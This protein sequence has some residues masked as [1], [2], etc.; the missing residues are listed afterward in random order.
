MTNRRATQAASAPDSSTDIVLRALSDHRRRAML[1]LVR[2]G[3]R[4]AGEI[5]SEF[6]ITQQAVSQH[7]QVL[8]QAGL[9][10]ERADGARRLYVLRPAALEPVRAVLDAL[11]PVALDR[12][13]RVV[14]QDHPPT[15]T[16]S[17]R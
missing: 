10:D 2:D 12:L 5:A 7:L 13:K 6:D 9:V 4:S 11:W 15:R 14:E 1:Q 8:R 17:R 3:E 16:R